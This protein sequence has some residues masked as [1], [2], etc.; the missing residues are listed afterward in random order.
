MDS[1]RT[2][3][4][5]PKAAARAAAQAAARDA[6]AL[7]LLGPRTH[8][9]LP[10]PSPHLDPVAAIPATNDDV[11]RPLIAQH[12][13]YLRACSLEQ[14]IHDY[15]S[16]IGI[17][18]GPVIDDIR[19]IVARFLAASSTVPAPTHPDPAI[20]ADP[21]G[22]ERPGAHRR[23][24]VARPDRGVR[25]RGPAPGRRHPPR[26]EGWNPW[27]PTSSTGGPSRS[28]PGERPSRG[29][30]TSP[31]SSCAPTTAGRT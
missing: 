21:A 30:T 11:A 22:V 27:N 19:A 29:L 16:H 24:L 23:R 10:A 28:T 9:H 25:P 6:D 12:G 31:D 26:M 7:T 2:H 1:S 20:A 14:P 13:I 15:A 5:N 4:P 8:L 18:H 3:T 17:N